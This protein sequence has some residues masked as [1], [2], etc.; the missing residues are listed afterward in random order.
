MN[1]LDH[2]HIHIVYLGITYGEVRA[3]YGVFWTPEIM[4]SVAGDRVG[5]EWL[6][7]HSP[8]PGKTAQ[9]Y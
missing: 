1:H 2:D 8:I 5:M 4:V 7:E 6:D 9:S 3:L